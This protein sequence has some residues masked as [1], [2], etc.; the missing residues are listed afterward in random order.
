[1]ILNWPPTQDNIY[2]RQAVGEHRLLPRRW[3]HYQNPPVG[4]HCSSRVSSGRK[5]AFWFTKAGQNGWKL[6]RNAR[7][8]IHW[9]LDES[10]YGASAQ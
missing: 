6:K 10:L 2:C 8:K 4:F 9:I 5:E 1:M 3:C 7:V